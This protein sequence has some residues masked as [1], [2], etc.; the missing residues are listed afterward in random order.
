ME[1]TFSELLVQQGGEARVKLLPA[2]NGRGLFATDEVSGPGEILLSVPLETCIVVDY[3]SGLRL[4]PGDWPRLRKAVAKNDALPW[5][6]LHALALLDGLAGSG[7]PFWS[8]Y[9]NEVLPDPL[10]VTL[11]T[12][13]PERL[14]T[15]LQHAEV[16]DAARKQKQRLALLFPGLA[17]QMCDG[18]GKR[19]RPRFCKYAPCVAFGN[20]VF[21]LCVA[22]FDAPC[23]D[24]PTWLEWAF[25][26]VRSRAFQLGPDC[27]AFVPFLDTANHAGEPNANF[28]LDSAK[29][30]VHLVSVGAIASGAEVTIR[31]TG[32]EGYTNQRL[33]A[34]YG[35][36]P[37]SGNPFDRLNFAALAADGAP[38]VAFSLDG[39]QAVLGDG[40]AMVDAF[41]GRDAY[42]Y[43]TLKSLPIASMEGD[44]APLKDQLALAETLLEE[45]ATTEAAWPTTLEEDEAQLLH[46]QE[47][48]ASGEEG[49][50][51]R[52][53]AVLQYRVQR[54]RLIEA[55]RRLLHAFIHR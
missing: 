54:K 30:T 4:A 11:P 12:C 45:V 2:A 34:Q 22:S 42:T 47:M 7:D 50:D 23:A 51:V 28:E 31:Y 37:S 17:S 33:M 49:A 26:C 24:G 41:S 3:A 52:L 16:E 9:T 39:L 10:H 40:E 18:K 36:V 53:A 25:A 38:Q 1:C 14:L 19:I 35:F 15:Q 6:I 32:Q 8:R 44:A 20:L 43:A 55:A 13:L 5:D 46:A 48:L 29:Q 21:Q 27:F